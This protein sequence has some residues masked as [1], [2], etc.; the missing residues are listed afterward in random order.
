MKKIL[1][2]CALLSVSTAMFA[3]K[4]ALTK[5]NTL[6]G[7]ALADV[8]QIKYDKV[9]QAWE[10]IQG[11][12]ANP[13][14]EV[15]PETWGTAGRIKA[16]YMNKMLTDR[17]LN[18][19][20]MDM[21]AF[22]DNQYDI[23]TF[24]SK[25]D[26]LYKVPNAKGKMA[27]D[28]DIAKNHTMALNNS[29]GARSNLLIAGNALMEKD[30]ARCRKFLDLYFKSFKDPL[31]ADLDLANTDSML[32]DAYLFYAVSL[33]NE[34]KTPEDTTRVAEYFEKATASKKNA[35]SAYIMLMDIAKNRDE[36]EKWAGYCNT[37]IEKFPTETAFPRNLINYYVR[38]NKLDDAI[39]TC[40]KMIQ[41]FPE[42]DYGYY[43]KAVSYYQQNKNTEALE[44]FKKA[45]EV[46]AENPESWAGAGN[47][48]WKL[49]R[50]NQ[51]NKAKAKPFYDEAIQHYLKVKELAPDKPE[52]WGYFLYAIYNNSGNTKEAANYKQYS[53]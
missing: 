24:Y 51:D 14:T 36:M 16:I 47:S 25:S 46:N 7:E 22:F 17:S 2:A 19:G 8:K 38:E 23:V 44:W 20:E 12:M 31:F 34:A 15:M 40:D 10:A 6:L 9:D 42:D 21:D 50:D 13:V 28:E 30:P 5:A 11:A 32:P 26:S 18:G 35:I 27:K 45:A 33:Q 4:S 43:W 1:F 37:G 39:A 41:N 48:A 52:L 53:K 29:H 3:Q 49:A